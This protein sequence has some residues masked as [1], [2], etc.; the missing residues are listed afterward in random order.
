[1]A[2]GDLTAAVDLTVV[3]DGGNRV[4]SC[5]CGLRD[6]DTNSENGEKAYAANEVERRETLSDQSS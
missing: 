4:K 5:S 6:F 3:V 1:M 2:E